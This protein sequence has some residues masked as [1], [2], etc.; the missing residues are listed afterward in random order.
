MDLP[1]DRPRESHSSVGNGI[2][3]KNCARHH[4]DDGSQ[5][6]TTGHSPSPHRMHALSGTLSPCLLIIK[7]D[8]CESK[9]LCFVQIQKANVKS[10]KKKLNDINNASDLVEPN[11]GAPF[12]TGCESGLPALV[13]VSIFQ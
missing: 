6:V 9:E 5:Q 4:T 2:A 13:S 7:D 11:E 12:Q 10:Y 3:Q 1:E 8:K